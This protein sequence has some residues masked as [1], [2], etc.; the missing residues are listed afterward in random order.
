MIKEVTKYQTKDG[1]LHD[2]IEGAAQWDVTSLG[3][4]NCIFMRSS[5]TYDLAGLVAE[6]LLEEYD[7]TKKP[8]T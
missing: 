7:I 6:M 8:T 2:T 1:T 5:L 3:L 4:Q